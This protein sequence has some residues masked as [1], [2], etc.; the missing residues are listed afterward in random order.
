MVRV[1]DRSTLPHVIVAG[2]G[3][4]STAASFALSAGAAV[5][6]NALGHH[7]LVAGI[8]DLGAVIAGRMT[9]AILIDEWSAQQRRHALTRFR[10]RIGTWLTR[11]SH[12]GRSYGDLTW[13]IEQVAN[14]NELTRLQFAAASSLLGL[15]IVLLSAGW[16]ATAT[17]VALVALA[18]PLYVR[19]GHRSERLGTEYESRR[20]QLESRQLEILQ[21]TPDLRGLGAVEYGV[22]EIGAFS[23]REHESAISAIRVALG[24]SLV[25]EFLSGVSIGLVA[26]IVGF[27]LLSGRISLLRALIAVFVTSEIFGAIRRYGVEFHRRDDAQ[28]AQDSLA[29]REPLSKERA[30]RLRARDIVTEADAIP[31]TFEVGPGQRVW[32]RG[33][34]GSGKTTLLETLVGW[35]DP[36]A[37]QVDWPDAPIGIIQ[38]HTPLLSGTL[39]ENLSL[40]GRAKD[41]EIIDALKSFNLRGPRFA[42][43]DVKLLA[44]GRGFSD[45][46][47]V[48]LLLVRALVNRAHTLIIDDVAGLLDAASRDATAAELGR[49]GELAIIEAAVE[50]PLIQAPT[51]MIEVGS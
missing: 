5:A 30:D 16:L 17:T 10:G 4:S 28:R 44:D 29:R 50:R 25:T 27:S 23:K 6:I 22:R 34:S 20:R 46:E 36:I 48:R 45:G 24:S 35:R 37:G 9:L 41:S 12:V 31:R 32:V 13:S 21:H 15:V 33:P 42:N 47:R 2:V 14:S 51:A 18:V 49:H 3:V 8:V 1:S 38:P 7:S 39:R 26:M 11:P 43:L 19:A 40:D